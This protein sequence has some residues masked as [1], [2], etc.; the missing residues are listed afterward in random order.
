MNEL[1][2]LCS[3][4]GL[5]SAAGLNAYI[6]LLTLGILQNRGMVSLSAPYDTLGSPW[7][8]ALL[9]F[10]LVVELIVDKIPG[11]D[12]VNDAI[13]TL[14]RPVAGAILFASQA[15]VLHGVHPAIWIVLGL[16]MSGGVHGAKALAR[17]AVNVTTAGVGAPVAS[18]V[19]NLLSLVMT[20]V[21][22]LAPLLVIVLL[23]VFGWIVWKIFR[24]FFGRDRAIRVLAI[25]VADGQPLGW[26]ENARVAEHP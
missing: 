25:P 1:L 13:M 26:P 9:A 11:A 3:A 22:V 5:S 15:G 21:A 18:A 20:I 17:P 16:L 24:H 4:F 10:L 2:K 7:C 6:P 8:L 23:G 19:E 14:G 12:H